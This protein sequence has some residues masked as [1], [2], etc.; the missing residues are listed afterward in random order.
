MC[1]YVEAFVATPMVNRE[2][3][4]G[5]VWEDVHAT[6]LAR[7]ERKTKREARDGRRLMFMGEWTWSPP[8]REAWAAPKGGHAVA[9]SNFL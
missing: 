6:P 8:G 1:V 5:C 4:C 7:G 3:A 2:G 9:K